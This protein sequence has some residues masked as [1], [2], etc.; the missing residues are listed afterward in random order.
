M[1]APAAAQ[2]AAPGTYVSPTYGFSLPFDASWQVIDEVSDEYGDS[3]YLFNQTSYM[4]FWGTDTYSGDVEECVAGT[5]DLMSRAPS[6]GDLSLATDVEG[7]PMTGGDATNAFAVFDYIYTNE[8]GTQEA[9]ALYT[10]C[11]TLVPGAS[12]LAIVQDVPDAAFNAEI[13]VRETLLEGLVLPELSAAPANEPTSGTPEAMSIAESVEVVG[14]DL[15]A[16]W[17]EQFVADGLYYIE[18]TYV[19]VDQPIAN[20]CAEEAAAMQPGDGSNYCGLNQVI[21]ID[22]LEPAQDEAATGVGLVSIVYTLAHEA[23]HNVEMQL[24]LFSEQR[25][26]ETELTADCLAGAYISDAQARGLVTA[27]EVDTLLPLIETFGDSAGE[28]ADSPTSHGLGTQRVTMFLRGLSTGAAG[29]V[30]Y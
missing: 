25:S 8:D 13:P 12:T 28:S 10:R 29:C 14:D 23:G 17:T 20:P 7:N 30:L 26:V 9:W 6:Y 22:A 4:L 21:Y 16:F 15:N 1:P 5:A 3:L 2:A 11:V 18:P 19:L 24:S 27:E